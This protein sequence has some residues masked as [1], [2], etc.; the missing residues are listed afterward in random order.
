MKAEEISEKNSDKQF[1]KHVG[2][3]LGKFD[4]HF[5]NFFSI[6]ILTHQCMH[7]KLMFSYGPSSCQAYKPF[8]KE[9]YQNDCKTSLVRKCG[10]GLEGFQGIEQLELFC[11]LTFQ[12]TS[13][14]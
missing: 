8:F 11:R 4:S 2:M 5:R 1:S 7:C 14:E 10:Q 12:L 9:M 6:S 3:L 13:F